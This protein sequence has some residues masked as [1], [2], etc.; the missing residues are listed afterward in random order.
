MCRTGFHLVGN[1]CIPQ[2]LD[3]EICPHAEPATA[4]TPAG[5]LP[6]H[7]DGCAQ[8]YNLD[9]ATVAAASTTDPDYSLLVCGGECNAGFRWES[10]LSRCVVNTIDEDTRTYVV[11]PEMPEATPA[12][13]TDPAIAAVIDETMVHLYGCAVC[14]STQATSTAD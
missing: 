14:I 10:L 8:C 5:V 6:E 9:T 13:P 7:I 4:T 12:T 11:C 3:L 1:N 2:D